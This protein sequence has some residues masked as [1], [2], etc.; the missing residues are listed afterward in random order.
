MAD[1]CPG[2]ARLTAEALELFH[3]VAALRAEND[4]L[5]AAELEPLT[6]SPD[7][8]QIGRWRQF[9]TTYYCTLHG[10]IESLPCTSCVQ[11]LGPRVE[12]P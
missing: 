10:E 3:E 7:G 9:P 6:L 11:W 4:R 8:M 1:E 12:L 2:C 5:R